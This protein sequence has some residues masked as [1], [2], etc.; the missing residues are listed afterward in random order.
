MKKYFAILSL[1]FFTICQKTALDYR[2]KWIGNY[3]AKIYYNSSYINLD[4]TSP[5]L[6]I[7]NLDSTE[8]NVIA[9]PIGDSSI[10]IKFLS[11]LNWDSLPSIL[12]RGTF[13]VESLKTTISWEE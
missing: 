9:L 5:I 1:I 7:Y 6:H 12:F 11:P 10:L 2:Y 4:H 8:G 13:V 3:K